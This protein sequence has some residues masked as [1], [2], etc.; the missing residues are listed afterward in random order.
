[1][2]FLFL[3]LIFLAGSLLAI[4]HV[5]IERGLISDS[6]VCGNNIDTNITDKS[7]ILKQLQNKISASILRN[8]NNIKCFPVFVSKDFHKTV[9]NIHLVGDAFFA[10]PP[11]FAQ[12][13]SQSIEGA[14][15]LFES[16]TNNKSNYYSN[17][18]SRV[19][20]INNR[21]KLNQFAFHVSNPI[22]VFFRNMGLKILTKNKTFLENYL[23][24]IYNN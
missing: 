9:E 15:E 16:I 24:K 23:G 19:K 17:R 12:G 10:F 20:M 21:S 13:A 14:S 11:S 6:F 18:V 7:E 3:S 4:Y 8:L 1:M 22:V 5:G 2:S